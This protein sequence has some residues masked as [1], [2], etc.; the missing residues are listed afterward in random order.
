MIKGGAG[1]EAENK[2]KNTR[3]K[4]EWRAEQGIMRV[5]GPRRQ[6]LLA[7]T[8]RSLLLLLRRPVH[9]HYHGV[10]ALI[11][12]Q[13][14]LRGGGGTHDDGMRPGERAGLDEE[15]RGEAAP[16]QNIARP[17]RVMEDG[18]CAAAFLDCAP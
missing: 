17:V 16:K 8:P 7:H 10:V 2:D 9:A 14:D 13:R 3:A 6:L 1:E 12:L 15:K 11:R 4:Q 18:S 5:C